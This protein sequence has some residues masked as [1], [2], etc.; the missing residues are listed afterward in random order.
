MPSRPAACALVAAIAGAGLGCAS[1]FDEPARRPDSITARLAAEPTPRDPSVPTTGDSADNPAPPELTPDAPPEDYVRFALSNSPEVRAAYQR[2]RASAER[3][4]QVAALPDPRLSFGFYLDEVETRVGPQQA[5]LGISQTFPWPGKLSGRK[6]AASRAAR[7]AWLQLEGVRLMTTERVLTAMHELAYLDAAT[8]IAREN[9]DLLA[10]FEDVVR[11]RYRVGAGSHPELVRV[12]V[13]LGQLQDRLAQL[14]AM[15]A[16]TVAT[17][18][19][20][21]GRPGDTAIPALPPLPP[22]IADTDAARLVAGARASNPTLLALDEQGESERA[23]TEVARKDALP[24]VTVGLDYVVTADAANPSMPESGDDPVMLTFGINLPLWR[25]KYEAGV[26]ESIARRLAVAG[27][28]DAQANRIEA[29]IARAWFDHT[30]ADRRV[31]LYEQTLIPK[32]RE[33]LRASLTA[34]RSDQ[35][36]FLDLLDTE[37]TL[38]EFAVSAQRA[39]ADRGEALARLNTLVGSPVPTRPEEPVPDTKPTP[40]E[41]TP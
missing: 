3:V 20:A 25:G 21:L 33:S 19:A 8:A 31:R 11:A 36:G 13:E 27:D 2:W 29:A 41:V 14:T 40:D 22:L 32:A 24:D 12:Q 28:R 5:R 34:F 39:R 38:L 30:D 15:R 17:L 6:D 7:A 1:P 18:N 4:P 26:R 35:A 9:L 10:S 37:R 16:P 23:M